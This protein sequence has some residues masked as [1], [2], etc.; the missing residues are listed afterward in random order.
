M[1]KQEEIWREESEALF[2]KNI[3]Q[4]EII[5]IGY[6]EARKKANEEVGLLQELLNTRGEL[7]NKNQIKIDEL[8]K[9]L[10]YYK[11]KGLI[12]NPPENKE[13]LGFLESL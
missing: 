4:K 3:L 10:L 12:G 11:S 6:L 5:W 1:N 7:L 8:K 9:E 13:A 2:G